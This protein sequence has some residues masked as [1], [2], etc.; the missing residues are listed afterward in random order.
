MGYGVPADDACHGLAPDLG[1][2]CRPQSH[3]KVR[4]ARFPS[5]PRADGCAAV[6]AAVGVYQLCL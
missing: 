4:V 5:V 1:F 6:R 3:R 2:G